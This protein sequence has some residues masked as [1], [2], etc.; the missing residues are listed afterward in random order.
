MDISWLDAQT[1]LAVAEAESM[2]GAARSL[3]LGQPT[4]SRR[5]A[6]LEG[7][8]GAQLFT[9]GKTGARL[10]DEGARLLPAAREMARW[11]GEF[12]RLASGAEAEAVGVVRVAAPPGFAFEFLA[13]LAR[14]AKDR[15]PGIRLEVLA[16]V[17]H[18]EL[19]RGVA[20]L[21]MRTRPPGEPEL[22]TIISREVELGVFASPEYAARVPKGATVADLDWITWAFPFEQLPPRPQLERWIPDFEAAFA[23]NDFLVQKAAVTAGLGVMILER[24]RTLISA[25][26]ELVELDVGLPPYTGQWHLV[27]AK[28]MTF[29]PRVKRVADLI[30]EFIGE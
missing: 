19:S 8:V 5:I 27:C 17:E 16:A 3:A 21:A 22:T 23:S 29:V 20:D 6:E 7:R 26:P 9:R 18:L 12:G 10:T 4:I 15:L 1:F 11:A 13:P 25:G 14:I 28:S 2:S 24:G 30:V